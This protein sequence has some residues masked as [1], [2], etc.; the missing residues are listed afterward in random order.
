MAKDDHKATNHHGSDG[1]H[2]DDAKY[3]KPELRAKLKDEIQKG[4]KGGRPGQWSARKSQFLVNEY[5][6]HGG[7]YTTETRDEA[8]K[9]LEQWQEEE[10]TTEDGKP[11]ERDDVMHRYLPK[12]AW[13]K[14]SQEERREADASKVTNSKGDTQ[15]VANTRAAREA[16]KAV[17]AD[18]QRN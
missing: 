5:E 17:S 10:W 7:G 18:H 3:T 1:H 6:K 16:R 12:E 11:A 2:Q 9:H 4:D 14:M 8:Q 13:E 15:Y